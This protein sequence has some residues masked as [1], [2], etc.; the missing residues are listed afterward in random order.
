MLPGL[1]LKGSLAI[2][3]SQ[4]NQNQFIPAELNPYNETYS[5]GLIGRNITWINEDII[6]YKH[7]F[8]DSHNIDLMAGFSAQADEKHDIRGFGQNGPDK[9]KVVN[10]A[11]NTFD[12]VRMQDL[13]DFMSDFTKSTMV[14]LFGRINYNYMQKYLAS[15]TIRRDAS[16]RFGE[17]VRWG[18]FPSVAL[19]YAFSEE[20]YMDWSDKVIDYGKIRL[21]YGKSGRYF[22]M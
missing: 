1:T 3:F 12:Q 18:T 19:G 10:W 22:C 14:G 15:F 21:S 6:T 5:A 20:S 7:T 9:M 17:N 4:Q 8:G 16:S 11:S 2:D 13:K